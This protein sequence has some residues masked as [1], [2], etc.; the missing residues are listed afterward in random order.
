MLLTA[1]FTWMQLEHNLQK[2]FQDRS[3]GDSLGL[4]PMQLVVYSKHK[5]LKPWRQLHFEIFTSSL[6]FAWSLTVLP[7]YCCHSTKRFIIFWQ[8][9]DGFCF[10]WPIKMQQLWKESSQV[11]LNCK[12][13]Q[14]RLPHFLHFDWPVETEAIR[15][16][17]KINLK[18]LCQVPAARKF[19]RVQNTLLVG[20]NEPK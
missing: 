18:K 5:V 15:K 13:W 3:K 9:P 12:N 11:C 10:N 2:L 7:T 4:S 8:L 19:H 14:V 16:V 17:S 20:E 6:N 1:L